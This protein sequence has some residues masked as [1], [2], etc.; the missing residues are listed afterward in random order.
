MMRGKIILVFLKGS[1]RD[2]IKIEKGGQG[3]RDEYE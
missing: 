1:L 2:G 3:E